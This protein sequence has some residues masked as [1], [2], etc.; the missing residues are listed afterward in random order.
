MGG[1][2]VIPHGFVPYL[3]WAGWHLLLP[4]SEIRKPEGRLRRPGALAYTRYGGTSLLLVCYWS[5]TGLL[6]FATVLLLIF[7]YKF[8]I[9]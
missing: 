2:Q 4:V 8:V 9:V 5:A 3:G 1:D 7:Y 6:L